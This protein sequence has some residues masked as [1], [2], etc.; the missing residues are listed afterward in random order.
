M[1]LT[2]CIEFIGFWGLRLRVY[3]NY[4]VL[5]FWFSLGFGK[6]KLPSVY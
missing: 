4:R 5:G 6:H 1:G 3:T 2:G